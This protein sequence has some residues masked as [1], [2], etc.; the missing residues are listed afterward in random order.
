MEIPKF[1][2]VTGLPRAG[3]TLLCQMLAQPSRDSMRRHSSPRVTK[4]KR[5]EIAPRIQA[6]IERACAWFYQ[7]YYPK[8]GAASTSAAWSS[9]IEA[10]VTVD[11]D[12][13]KSLVFSTS[14]HF[15]SDCHVSRLLRSHA[16]IPP[17]TVLNS[18]CGSNAATRRRER[19]SCGLRTRSLRNRCCLSNAN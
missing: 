10:T 13:R 2:G 1:V 3:S 17:E 4:P 11:H 6:Q 9:G 7:F 18:G 5:H 19:Y 12:R 8:K 15:Y 16:S 14:E